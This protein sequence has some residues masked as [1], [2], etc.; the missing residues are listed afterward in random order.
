MEFW[1]DTTAKF[2]QIASLYS[3]LIALSSSGQLYQWRWNDTD[4][5]RHTENLNIHHPKTIPLGLTNEKV[6][7]ISA[8]TARC[9]VSTESGKVATWLDELLA[10]AASKLEQAAQA[11][12]EFQI[13]KISAL[14]TCP[15]YTVAKLESGALYWW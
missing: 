9:S 14:H 1:P 15:L 7:H 12:S 4:P 2:T 11:Y 3:E 6:V 13:D 8:C 10:P 5:Y